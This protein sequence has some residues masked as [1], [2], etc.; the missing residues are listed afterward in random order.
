MRCRQSPVVGHP[1]QRC[2][3]LELSCVVDK[4]HKRTTKRRYVYH[5]GNIIDITHK[6][7]VPILTVFILSKLEKLEQELDAIKQAFGPKTDSEEPRPPRSPR[8]AS[9]SYSEQHAGRLTASQRSAFQPTPTSLPDP[10]AGHGSSFKATAR[11]PSK[12]IPAQSRTI[13]SHLVPGVDI[14]WYFDK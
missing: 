10:P 14:D 1:C 4:S 9:L 3:K 12:A 5:P 7:V 2:D 6:T 13:G 11:R 8:A